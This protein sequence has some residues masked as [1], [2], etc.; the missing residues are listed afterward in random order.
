MTSRLLEGL[1]RSI[2][3]PLPLQLEARSRLPKSS[4]QKFIAYQRQH[5]AGRLDALEQ[6]STFTMKDILQIYELSER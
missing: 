2:K 4:F 1:T 3:D 5:D 6:E